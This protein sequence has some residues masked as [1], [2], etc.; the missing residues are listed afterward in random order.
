MR[1]DLE[2]YL[3]IE[4]FNLAF[5]LTFLS[6]LTTV[7]LADAVIFLIENSSGTI[8][9]WSDQL[10]RHLMQLFH[11]ACPIQAIGSSA[12]ARQKA[13]PDGL[14]IGAMQSRG[15]LVLPLPGRIGRGHKLLRTDL[16]GFG[17]RP[18]SQQSP[19][20][21]TST[22]VGCQLSEAPVLAFGEGPPLRPQHHYPYIAERRPNSL[23]LPRARRESANLPLKWRV[24]PVLHSGSQQAG[25]EIADT[26]TI[27]L[28]LRYY[29]TSRCCRSVT[30]A[31]K[32]RCDRFMP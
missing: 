24:G 19:K 1:N 32:E 7:P 11:S 20:T 6:G 21:G 16:K 25:A 27:K 3:G 29:R 26:R 13:S 23:E 2:P 10:S 17:N 14:A 5:C 8:G 12:E 31:R 18:G 30:C 9:R 4:R 28:V 22:R 15:C